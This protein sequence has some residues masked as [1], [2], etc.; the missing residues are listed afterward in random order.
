V[1]SHVGPCV[2]YRFL[3]DALPLPKA[4]FTKHR[5]CS[6]DDI[7]VLRDLRFGLNQPLQSAA[8]R[9]TCVYGNITTCRL[10][11]F[12]IILIT[13]FLKPNT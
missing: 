6:D 2:K 10:G 5:F 13:Q 3:S 1:I 12:D 11:D 4:K 7:K 8:D 9:H